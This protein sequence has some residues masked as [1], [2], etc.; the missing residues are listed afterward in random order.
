MTHESK[1][2]KIH[3]TLERFAIEMISFTQKL[4]TFDSSII[5]IFI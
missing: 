5:A 2:V 4:N 3:L 1:H